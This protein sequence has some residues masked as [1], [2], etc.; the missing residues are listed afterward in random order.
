MDTLAQEGPVAEVMAIPKFEYFFKEAG[1][2]DVDK[3]DL[4]RY[5]EFIN[6]KMY[7]LLVRAQGPAKAN[8][9]DIIEPYDLPITRGLHECILAFRK[10][11]AQIEL[12]PILDQL[13]AR[14][15]L[16]LDYSAETEAQFPEIVGGLSVALARNF[17]ILDPKVKNPASDEWQRSFRTFDL[18]L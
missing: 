11:D 3:S 8:G 13:T 9:R 14:P 10:I 17:K 1:G 2:V 6:H 7:D 16:D 12:Q 4:R 15:P 5:H 18:L